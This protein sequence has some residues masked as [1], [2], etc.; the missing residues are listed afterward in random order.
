[1]PRKEAIDKMVEEYRINLENLFVENRNNISDFISQISN[2]LEQEE[3][4]MALL[5]I[6]N[7]AYL[8]ALEEYVLC[9]KNM[10]EELLKGS[11]FYYDIKH[12]THSYDGSLYELDIKVD[13]GNLLCIQFFLNA[14]N[15]IFTNTKKRVLY[16]TPNVYAVNTGRYT[17]IQKIVE[18]PK[19]KETIKQLYQYKKELN[20]QEWGPTSQK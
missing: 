9:S 18:H 15:M 14:D 2:E 1:M 4:D 6:N 13:E 8:K 7:Q 5:E 19:F 11:G 12:K 3:K 16:K 10:I 17:S 20:R